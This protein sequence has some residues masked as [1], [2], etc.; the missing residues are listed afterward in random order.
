MTGEGFQISTYTRHL[1]PVRF[2]WCDTPTVTGA[3][4][5]NGHLRGAVVLR[6][7]AERLALE[8]LPTI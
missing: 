8:L 3:T 7:V 6:P 5:Y 1:L 2:L 4:V